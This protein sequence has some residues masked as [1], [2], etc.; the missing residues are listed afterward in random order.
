MVKEPD[1]HDQDGNQEDDADVNEDTADFFGGGFHF[2]AGLDGENS[3]LQPWT[4]FV[5]DKVFFAV[6]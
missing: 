1:G 4:V 6:F 3:E 5:I 2:R